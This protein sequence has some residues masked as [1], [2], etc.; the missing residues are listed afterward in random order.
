M[1]ENGDAWLCDD[2][3][4]RQTLVELHKSFDAKHISPPRDTPSATSTTTKPASKSKQSKKQRVDGPT[5]SATNDTTT[6]TTTTTT[7]SARLSLSSI[8][9]ATQ[10]CCAVLL[11]SNALLRA[12]RANVVSS[13]S[14]AATLCDARRTLLA[15]ALRQFVARGQHAQANAVR[16]AASMSTMT[17]ST[18]MHASTN[19]GALRADALPTL[20]GV[21]TLRMYR[22]ALLDGALVAL[23]PMLLQSLFQREICV[24]LFSFLF[25]F[26][27]LSLIFCCCFSARWLARCHAT[28]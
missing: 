6:T 3:R 16:D 1:F 10:Q 27:F 2:C 12:A 7:T 17:T 8:D 21:G 9:S 26:F 25:F 18:M 11:A 14:A 22:R 23:F 13:A 20:S 5:T 19:V 4:T 24:V 15:S 28:G